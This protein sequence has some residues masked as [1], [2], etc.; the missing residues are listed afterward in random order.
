[1]THESDESRVKSHGTE[2]KEQYGRKN[3]DGGA[4]H[5]PVLD[6]QFE[7]GHLPAIYNA[8]RVT[9]EGFNIPTPLDVTSRWS[10]TWARTRS[11]GGHGAD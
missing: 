1:V 6:I 2:L 9:S 11:R 8:V 5:W 7:A 10:S 4:G 3:V